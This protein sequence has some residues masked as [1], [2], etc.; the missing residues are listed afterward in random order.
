[1]FNLD[2]DFGFGFT[3]DILPRRHVTQTILCVSN[4]KEKAPNMQ[5]ISL[6]F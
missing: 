6:F 5:E 2:W 4:E 3:F 1:M